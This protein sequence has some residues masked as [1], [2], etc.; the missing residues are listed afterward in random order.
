MLEGEGVRGGGV[1]Q[2]HIVVSEIFSKNTFSKKLLL[3]NFL[4]KSHVS[5]NKELEKKPHDLNG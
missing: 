5:G 4:L 3:K 2:V 1:F